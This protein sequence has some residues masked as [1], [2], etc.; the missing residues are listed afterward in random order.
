MQEFLFLSKMLVLFREWLLTPKKMWEIP[1]AAGGEPH[2]QIPTGITLKQVGKCSFFVQGIQIPK[3]VN[4]VAKLGHLG[5]GFFFM[6][7]LQAV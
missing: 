1:L 5:F 2:T 6:M 3:L 4:A 7:N